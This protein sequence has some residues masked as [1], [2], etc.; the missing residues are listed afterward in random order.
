MGNLELVGLY[1]G[2]NSQCRRDKGNESGN[3]NNGAI[4]GLGLRDPDSPM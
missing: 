2:P 1:R 3:Y 4:Q